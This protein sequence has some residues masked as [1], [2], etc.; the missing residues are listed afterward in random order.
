MTPSSSRATAGD[1]TAGLTS[2]ARRVVLVD[3]VLTFLVVI[4]VVHIVEVLILFVVDVG[5]VQPGHVVGIRGHLVPFRRRVELGPLRFVAEVNGEHSAVQELE[6]V[7]LAVVLGLGLPAEPHRES[8]G[9]QFG[10][11]RWPRRMTYLRCRRN[12]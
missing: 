3:L 11:T 4:V 6:A 9:G 12:V 2:P 7:I 8:H 5:R 1:E 10:M